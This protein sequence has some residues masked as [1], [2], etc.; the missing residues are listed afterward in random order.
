[1]SR[2]AGGNMPACSIELGRRMELP[3]TG[4][5]Y[6]LTTISVTF[7]GFAALIAAFRQMVGG[8]LT[9]HDAFLIRSALMRSLIVIICALLPPLL[10]LFEISP[11]AIWRTSSFVS[12]GLI[13]AF[14]LAW[15]TIVRRNATSLPIQPAAMA[16]H[17][18]QLLAA[19]L[20]LA[21]ALGAFSTL[22]SGFFVAALTVFMITS[23]ISVLVSLEI[24]FH[25]SGR[26][27]RRK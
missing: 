24:L 13:A 16:Y 14:T 3:A 7:A 4:Y 15:P 2:G 20:L 23:W 26:A 6:N 22:A 5:L 1:M 19:L 25:S 9:K 17:A 8:Q 27:V 11:Q 21:I 18:L 12:A 10:A